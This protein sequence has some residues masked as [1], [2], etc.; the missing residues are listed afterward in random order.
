MKNLTTRRLTSCLPEGLGGH[1]DGSLGPELLLLGA[2]DEVGAHLLEGLDVPGGQ[3]DADAV[4]GRFLAAGGLGVL[5][6]RLKQDRLFY[7]N[8][9]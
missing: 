6:S 3:G 9:S 1:P 8:V 4:D 7:S 5:V 2:L